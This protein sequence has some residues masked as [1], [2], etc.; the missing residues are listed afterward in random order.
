MREYLKLALFLRASRGRL[1]GWQKVLIW[2]ELCGPIHWFQATLNKPLSSFCVFLSQS[3]SKK[4][5]N[6]EML[7]GLKPDSHKLLAEEHTVPLSRLV[8]RTLITSGFKTHNMSLP[9]R[10]IQTNYCGDGT[11]ATSRFRSS[12]L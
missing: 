1:L 9:N 10:R 11:V 12:S 8:H 2:C 3:Q 7:R 5:I 4:G 6:Q